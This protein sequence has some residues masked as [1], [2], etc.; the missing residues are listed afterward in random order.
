[1]TNPK[2][3]SEKTLGERVIEAIPD[4][5]LGDLCLNQLTCIIDQLDAQRSQGG[6]WTVVKDQR[7]PQDSVFGWFVV[8]DAD[9]R[10]WVE[11][12]R[13]ARELA[14]AHNATLRPEPRKE[15]K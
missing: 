13:A 1:M 4:W 3:P 6:E 12:E 8:I 10:I 2:Q 11:H 15:V 14:A 9:N 5:W 7:P